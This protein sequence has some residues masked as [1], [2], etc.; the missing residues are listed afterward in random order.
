[1]SILTRKPPVDQ[2]R[3]LADKVRELETEVSR[4]TLD[5]NILEAIR[6]EDVPSALWWYQRKCRRQRLALDRLNRRVLS[7]RFA[8]RAMD[9]LGMRLSR[10]Q[11]TEAR[12]A[13]REELRERIDAEQ[14]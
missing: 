2:E 9:R 13:E 5:R 3:Y 12:N 11:Y 14:A 4:L 1:M 10:E 8:L 7:Q 6:K